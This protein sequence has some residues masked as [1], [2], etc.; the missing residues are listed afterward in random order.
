MTAIALKAGTGLTRTQHDRLRQLVHFIDNGP[1]SGVATGAIEEVT[2]SGAFPTDFSWY[3]DA[4]KT[5]RIVRLQV[6][7]SGAFPQTETWTIYDTDGSTVLVTLVDTI[8]YAGAFE[9]GRA[10]VWS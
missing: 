5:D 1:G 4:T 9:S 7:Y 3:T 2:Y 8:A 10:R 6:T